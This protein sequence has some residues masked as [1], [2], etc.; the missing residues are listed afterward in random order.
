MA[1][2]LMGLRVPASWAPSVE[3]LQAAWD[4]LDT[5]ERLGLQAAAAALLLLLCASVLVNPALKTLREAPA[6]LAVVETQLAQMQAWATEAKR[7]QQ[8]PSVPGAQAQAALKGATEH[9]G[10]EAKLVVQGDRATLTFSNLSGEALGNWLAET[11]SAARARPVEAQIQRGPRGY[12]G[13]VV[14]SVGG[15]S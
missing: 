11:R 4:R 6:R 3:K 14:L 12:G 13:T 9:L 10:P 8:L 5:R 1:T 2:S 7:L 15:A